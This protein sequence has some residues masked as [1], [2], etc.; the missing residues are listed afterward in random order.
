MAGAISTGFAPRIFFFQKFSCETKNLAILC[1]RE[2]KF[3]RE[4]FENEESR[5][6]EVSKCP[7][8]SPNALVKST[9]YHFRFPPGGGRVEDLEEGSRRRRSLAWLGGTGSWNNR[10][11]APRPS[12]VGNGSTLGRLHLVEFCENPIVQRILIMAGW[13]NS[14]EKERAIDIRGNRTRICSQYSI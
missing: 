10:V 11:F 6:V 12:P 3:P 2:K 14:L 13:E 7:T 5:S 4:I 9:I 1:D 8:L